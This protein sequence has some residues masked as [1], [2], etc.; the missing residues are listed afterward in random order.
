ME[1]WIFYV[2]V[3][4]IDPNREQEF[5][6][7]YDEIH[8]PDV[9]EGCTDFRNCQRYKLISRNRDHGQYLTLIE[10]ETDDIEQTMEM[11]RKNSERIRAEGRWTDIID[12]RTRKLYKLEKEFNAILP[13]R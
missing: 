1:K 2:E 9:M 6:R 3:S 13:D 7:W 5:N 12:V 11:H 10:I 4:C 8:I